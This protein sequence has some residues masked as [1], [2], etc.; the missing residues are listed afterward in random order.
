MLHPK[1][2]SRWQS[3]QAWACLVLGIWLAVS[4]DHLGQNA[5]ATSAASV[6]LWAISALLIAISLLT[7]LSAYVTDELRVS[8]EAFDIVLGLALIAVPLLTGYPAGI[9][10]MINII[11]VGALLVALSTFLECCAP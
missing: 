4:L 6:F 9:I 10:P 5:T 11:L 3:R 7:H 8:E 1:R 2:A